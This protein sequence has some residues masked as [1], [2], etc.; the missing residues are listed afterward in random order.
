M[1]YLMLVLFVGLGAAA[2]AQGSTGPN[3]ERDKIRAYFKVTGDCQI[4]FLG[5]ASKAEAFW[6]RFDGYLKKMIQLASTA[7]ITTPSGVASYVALAIFPECDQTKQQSL[8]FRAVTA[9]MEFR[10]AQLMGA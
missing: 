4:T 10:L 3:A 1:K 2:I 7:F 6:R 9:A 5:D 8:S